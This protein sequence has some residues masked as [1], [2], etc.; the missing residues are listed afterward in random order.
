MIRVMLVDDHLI[1]RS[2]VRL[3]LGTADDIT[4]AC[5]AE[6]VRDALLQAEKEEIDVAI[7]DI[8]LPDRSGLELLKLLKARKPKLAVLVLSMYAEDIYAVR[9]LRAGASGYLTKNSPA[10]IIVAAVHKAAAG[11]KYITPTLVEKFAD[12]LVG[13]EQPAHERLSDRELEVLKHIA[14]GS[15]LVRIAEMLNLSPH[16]VTTYRARILEKMGLSSNVEIAR[17]AFENDLL[18]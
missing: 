17:Y 9:A 10:P 13:E 5:E 3:M 11:G 2:G 6:T 16:T 15:S 1:V 4:V 8:A 18:L 12:L 14:V 7:I